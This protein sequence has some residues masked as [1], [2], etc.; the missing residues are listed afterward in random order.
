MIS[1]T[2]GVDK[3]VIYV[4]YRRGK[5]ETGSLKQVDEVG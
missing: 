3:S 2:A 1:S 4:F 5:R